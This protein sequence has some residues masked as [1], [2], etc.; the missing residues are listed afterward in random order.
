MYLNLAFFSCL[1]SQFDEG[2]D[3]DDQ[4]H[5][6]FNIMI[7]RAMIIDYSHAADADADDDDDENEERRLMLILMMMMMV[8]MMIL[9]MMMV[10]EETKLM[11]PEPA[12]C[13]SAMS[14]IAHGWQCTE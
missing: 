6:L 5:H 11:T 2:E 9:M 12:S 7:I 13:S 10:M 3:R 4:T 8:L 14:W 1:S